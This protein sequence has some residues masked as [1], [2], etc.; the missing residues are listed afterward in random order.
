MSTRP[1][2]VCII[3]TNRPW[4]NSLIDNLSERIDMHF[5][6]ISSPSELSL[7]KL[8]E[9]N[10]Q[11]I[12]FPHWSYKIEKDI[13]SNFECVIFHMTDLPFGRGG[14]P[15]QNLIVRGI[16]ETQ[17]SAIQCIENMDAG[18]IYLKKP[19]SLY[20]SA[21][22]IFLRASALI[23]DMVVEIL[24]NSPIPQPQKGEVTV[25]KRRKPEDGN[26]K[27]ASTLNE[28]FDLIR[29]LDADC[30]PNAYIDFG[31]FKL[32]FSRASLKSNHLFADVK[33][34]LVNTPINEVKNDKNC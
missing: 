1:N 5:K 16:Y 14:S 8:L 33:I 19:L 22:E 10:P 26:L 27:N 2:R 6:L 13:Y 32:E 9:I 18:S 25:F 34:S 28:V 30:Y 29:M 17:I 7:S 31:S 15:L 24:E 11:F 4:N 21:E 23:E 3:A 20:G 12:F